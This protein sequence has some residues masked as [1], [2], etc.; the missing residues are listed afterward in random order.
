[1]R[2]LTT[3]NFIEK[4]KIKHGD[5]YDYSKSIYINRRTKLTIICNLHG[6]FLQEAGSHMQ[7]G[8]GCPK[9]SHN[10]RSTSSDFIEKA[11]KVHNHKYRYENI[12]YRNAH[13]KVDIEYLIH[14]MFEQTPNSHL[15][16]SGCQKCNNYNRIVNTENFIKKANLKHN[17]FYNY[18]KSVYTPNGKTTIICPIHG[19]FE[20]RVSNHLQ[21]SGCTKCF[22][23]RS[24]LEEEIYKFAKT[25]D[26]SAEY[27]N[28]NLI[29]M[30]LDIIL[31]RFKMAIEVN[32]EYWHYL[33]KDGRKKHIVKSNLCKKQGY[34]LFHLREILWNRNSEHIKKVIIKIIEKNGKCL[35]TRL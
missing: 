20:Q 13:S 11:N 6:E 9:C 34:V 31:P 26:N 10:V 15:K 18:D 8:R 30:E 17:N 23:K 4:S 7:G 3:D 27:S 28:K 22:N 32:G 14:G 29:G 1:M 25:L 19:D 21:G 12:E 2:K 35:Y 16:G 24:K 5:R 33:K